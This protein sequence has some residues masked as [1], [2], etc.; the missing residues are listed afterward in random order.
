M[1][2]L[3]VACI[4]LV[5]AGCDQPTVG[6][7]AGGDDATVGSCESDTDCDDGVFCDGAEQCLDGPL[8][9]ARGCSPAASPVCAVGETCSETER[10]CLDHCDLT[11]DADGDTFNAIDCGGADCDDSDAQR[12][13][14]NVETCDAENRDE[15]C[16]PLTFGSRDGD[17]DGSIDSTCCNVDEAG[18]SHCGDDCDDANIA[19]RP[20][21][22]ENCNGTDDDCNGMV[23]VDSGGINVCSCTPLDAVESCGTNTG[24]CTAGT[25]TCTTS[26]WGTCVGEVGRRAEVCDMLDNDCDGTADEVA[27]ATVNCTRYPNSSPACAVG[28]GCSFTCTSGY[29]DCDGNVSTGCETV[30]AG[31]VRIND[32]RVDHCGGC[33]TSPPRSCQVTSNAASSTATCASGACGLACTSGYASCD[34]IYANGCETNTTNNVDRCGSCTNVCPTRT[35]ATRSCATSTCGFTCTSGYGNCDAVATN[36]CENTLDSLTH[37]GACNTACARTNATATCATTDVCRISSCSAGWGNCDGVDSNGCENTVDSLTHCGACNTACARANATATCAT[38]DVCRISSCNGGYGNCD[39]VDANGCETNTTNNS[40]HCNG[41]N[42]ACAA[43]L[44]CNSSA[45]TLGTWHTSI[46]YWLDATTLRGELGTATFAANNTYTTS[47]RQSTGTAYNFTGSWTIATG[48]AV[49]AVHA[50]RNY[51]GQL[52]R[53]GDVFTMIDAAAEASN[54]RYQAIWIRKVTGHAVGNL[55]GDWYT[56]SYNDLAN[57]A[58]PANPFSA[59]GN[60][61]FTAAGAM[62]ANLALSFGGTDTSTGTSVVAS[63]GTVTISL[64]GGSVLRG[65][66][67]EF[68]DV[69]VLT[70]DSDT[71]ET[72]GFRPGQ[73]FL[74][75]KSSSGLSSAN[76]QG[77]YFLTH[78]VGTNRTVWGTAIATTGSWTGG[79]LFAS[80]LVGSIPVCSGGSIAVTTTGSTTMTLPNG[81]ACEINSMIAGWAQ[82]PSSSRSDVLVAHNANTTVNSLQVW[83]RRP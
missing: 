73:L 18:V 68:N 8:A 13:P 27:E 53:R 83:I 82:F 46:L 10:R 79:S 23:D 4:A 11:P 5:I 64:S 76:V 28:G 12:Y 19:A 77:T 38:T 80:N 63:D 34:A 16:N 33:G 6:E 58:S 31:G 22:T 36:G 35:N 15:D 56:A 78:M 37:C 65:Q 3:I 42:M 44:R 24:E 20:G 43:H 51:I 21:A 69:M 47:Y 1:R 59:S 32:E 60:I 55:A 75:K 9:D 39:S 40:S 25:R 70:F 50:G 52:S 48:N 62:S 71:S 30:L 45:C 54:L 7:D 66:I 61:N 49:T 74:V 26:G 67:G 17:G 72:N 81:G 57:G 2:S 14:D 41:C 29:G